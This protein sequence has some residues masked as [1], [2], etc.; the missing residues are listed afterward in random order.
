MSQIACVKVIIKGRVQGVFFRAE[1]KR[2]ADLLNLTG[3]VKN[4]ADGSVEALFQGE[5]TAVKKMIQWSHQGPRASRVDQVLEEPAQ[6]L[7][8]GHRFEI[9]Y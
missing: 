6:P 2:T 8:G 1:T 3:Y 9:R 4:L 5:E 7:P